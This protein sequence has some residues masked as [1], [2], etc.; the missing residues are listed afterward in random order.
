MNEE[1]PRTYIARCAD[2]DGVVK[3]M[4]W[5]DPTETALSVA[6]DVM[7]GRVVSSLSEQERKAVW[8]TLFPMGCKCEKP[9]EVIH[10]CANCGGRIW[11]DEQVY[12]FSKPGM[13]ILVLYYHQDCLGEA[14]ANHEYAYDPENWGTFERPDTEAAEQDAL[15]EKRL[16]EIEAG[17]SRLFSGG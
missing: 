17:Q 7:N 12:R 13:G 5:D 4:S 16:A 10:N 2:C 14:E 11:R 8:D 1:R 3:M 9:K 15:Y 6:A